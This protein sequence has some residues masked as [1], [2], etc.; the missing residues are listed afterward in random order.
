MSD[1]TV[2]LNQG[3]TTRERKSGKQYTTITVQSEP[4][5]HDLDPRKLGA[6]VA[7]AIAEHIRQ[8][9]LGITA[10]AS[11]ATLARRKRAAVEAAEG[12]PTAAARYGGGRIG[13]TPPA[14]SDRLFND[15][16]RLAKGIVARANGEAFVVNVAANRLDSTTFTK[17]GAFERM[18]SLL[19]Q[20]VPE[21]RDP[22]R[23]M[24]AIPIRRAVKDGMAAMIQKQTARISELR[25]ERV[26]A[27]V[28]L[29]KLALVG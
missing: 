14:Q 26:R 7:V 12:Q 2:V 25:E 21:I 24:D 4:L 8:R 6:P 28:G 15:S 17:A 20:Y 29:V 3:F 9:I 16:G 19:A 18:L 13:S 5:I 27:V 10:V 23:L 22:K 11:A 1:T